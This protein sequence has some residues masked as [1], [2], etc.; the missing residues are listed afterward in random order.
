MCHNYV[1]IIQWIYTNTWI[2]RRIYTAQWASRQTIWKQLGSEN[3]WT[4]EFK[5]NSLES[6][7]L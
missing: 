7:N 5:M 6:M 1:N 3:M 2:N 4:V